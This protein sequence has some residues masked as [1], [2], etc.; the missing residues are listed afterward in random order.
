MG[1]ALLAG[2]WAVGVLPRSA[3]AEQPVPVVSGSKPSAEQRQFFTL[4]VQPL[5]ERHC[6]RCHGA[7]GTPKGGLRLTSRQEVLQG[8]E[9]GPAVSL[10]EPA[11]SLLLQAINYDG[12]EMPPS[13]KLPASEIAVL[14]NWVK[15]GL[16]WSEGTAGRPVPRPTTQGSP[17]VNDE[18][19]RFWSFQ[20]VVRPEL[21]AAQ[22]PA[23]SHPIDRLL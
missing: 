13:G 3:G 1:W 16:A 23:G 15:S 2:W 8:G 18:T 9:S 4:Q 22:D 21:P 10:E 11:K 20:P 19:K 7:A 12:F 14:T 6:L 5:L 17:P